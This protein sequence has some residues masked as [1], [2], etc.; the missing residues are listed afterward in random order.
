MFQHFDKEQSGWL[1]EIISHNPH[2]FIHAHTFDELVGAA[3]FEDQ[4]RWGAKKC[5][6]MLWGLIQAHGEKQGFWT[7]HVCVR[8]RTLHAGEQTLNQTLLPVSCVQLQAFLTPPWSPRWNCTSLP[9]HLLV[10]VY[11]EEQW[12]MKLFHAQLCNR[13]ICCKTCLRC[14][15]P[16]C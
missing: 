12:I 1:T 8:A 14:T 7:E 6:S 3:A 5:I 10:T 13:T 16:L 15:H 2:A 4:K 9:S 11:R